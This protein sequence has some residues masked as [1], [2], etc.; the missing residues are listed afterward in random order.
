MNFNQLYTQGKFPHTE[1]LLD[2]IAKGAQASWTRNA[3]AAKPAWWGRMAMSNK[4]GG[5]G[6]IRIRRIAGG[7]QV[8]HPNKGKYNYMAVIERGRPRYDMRP[9]LLG[10][11]RARMGPNGPYVIVPIFHNEDGSPISPVRN[12]INSVIIKKGSRKEENAH[13]KMVTRNT[14]KY[15]KDPGMSGKGDYFAAEQ[16]FKDGSIQ[17][18]YMKFVVVT[19]HSTDFFHPAIPAQRILAGVKE[20]VAEALKSKMLKQAVATDCKALIMDLISKKK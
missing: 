15:R 20:D 10:G 14:Y 3:L 13:G 5:G 19:E 9:A 11:S 6:G 8:Y 17:R 4:P 7:F 12:V 16:K 18:S 2:K 1:A